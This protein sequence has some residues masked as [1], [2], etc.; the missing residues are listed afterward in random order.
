MSTV[1]PVI[2]CSFNNIF[3]MVH[4]MNLVN[5]NRS[6]SSSSI[7]FFLQTKFDICDVPRG[8]AA[9]KPAIIP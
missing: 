6:Q 1:R 7:Q 3:K 4:F 2:N 9:I 5:S 8:W